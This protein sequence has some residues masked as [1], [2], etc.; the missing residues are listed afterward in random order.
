MKD[1]NIKTPVFKENG[2]NENV[3]ASLQENL[4]KDLNDQENEMAKEERK[5]LYDYLVDFMVMSLDENEDV[6]NNN[7]MADEDNDKL[8]KEL[9]DI[10][11]L[12]KKL[13][14]SMGMKE[15][16]FLHVTKMN[17]LEKIKIDY[18]FYPDSFPFLTMRKNLLL[19]KKY[20][21]F[22]FFY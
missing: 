2:Y 18:G 6:D 15:C 20:I 9:N 10:P 1:D 19:L 12:Y 4:L 11:G 3:E 13:R 22:F 5:A 17:E 16:A 14:V 7:F 21:F 8:Q